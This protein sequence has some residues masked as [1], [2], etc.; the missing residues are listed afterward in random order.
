MARELLGQEDELLF[1]DRVG[2]IVVLGVEGED[3]KRTVDLD[4]LVVV[5]G[6]KHHP[7]AESPH[8]RPAHL[9]ENR[10]APDVRQPFGSLGLLGRTGP[11]EVRPEVQLG[12]ARE[13]A[14]QND[15][16][17]TGGSCR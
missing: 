10:V 15:P 11:G 7:A 16:G 8:G 12:A 3:G 17:D 2:R 4:R 1:G 6:V 5:L 9:P 14:E 13:Q